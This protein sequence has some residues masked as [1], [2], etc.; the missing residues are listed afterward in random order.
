[1]LPGS[2]RQKAFARYV[3]DSANSFPQLLEEV[4][5]GGRVP[6]RVPFWRYLLRIV[7]PS[8]PSESQA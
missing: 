1:M 3:L 4:R 8:A 6:L 2:E 5:S 7:D